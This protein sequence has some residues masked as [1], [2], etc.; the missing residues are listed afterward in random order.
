MSL[1]FI[2]FEE[3]IINSLRDS[4]LID[5][6]SVSEYTQTV[7]QEVL[8][9]YFREPKLIY[10]DDQGLYFDDDGTKVYC[11]TMKTSISEKGEWLS[12]KL[13]AIEFDI[14]QSG[15]VRKADEAEAM[16][17]CTQI[18]HI[19]NDDLFEDEFRKVIKEYN[20]EQMIGRSDPELT[21]RNLLKDWQSLQSVIINIIV[22]ASKF[23]ISYAK[24][25]AEKFLKDDLD[26][27]T[28]ASLRELE[29]KIRSI[30]F[31]YSQGILS[32]LKVKEL[33]K[34]ER[35]KEID[36]RDR[37]IFDLIKLSP[38]GNL[39]K[40]MNLSSEYIT[41]MKKKQIASWVQCKVDELLSDKSFELLSS[42]RKTLISKF[43]RRAYRFEKT[44]I[45]KLA[46]ER[47]VKDPEEFKLPVKL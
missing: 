47:Y 33:T 29:T 39:Y 12:N 26:E 20:F 43:T 4:K 44:S 36:D 14:D 8:L 45:R 18:V 5:R 32:P 3:R 46:V 34:I 19:L 42:D 9:K 13:P 41:P 21:F 23:K 28:I 37:K 11:P 35:L 7:D 30:N 40:A 2:E 27:E 1:N 24:K 16:Y 22:S 17:V 31:E 25:D 15:N 10:F 6:F 38:V